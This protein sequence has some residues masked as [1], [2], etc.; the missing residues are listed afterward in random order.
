MKDPLDVLTVGTEELPP[1]G[2]DVVFQLGET[3]LPDAASSED[4]EP[5][6]DTVGNRADDLLEVLAVGIEVLPPEGREVVFQL[7]DKLL[8][9]VASEEDE[10]GNGTVGNDTNDPLDVLTVGTDTL[11]PDGREVLFQLGP[12]LLPEVIPAEED[13]AEDEAL[14]VGNEVL[15]PGGRAVLFQLGPTLLPEVSTPEDV[16]KGTKVPLGALVTGAD[17]F[18]PEGRDVLFQLGPKLLPEL[19]WLDSDKVGNGTNVPLEILTVGTE[20]FPLDVV[21]FQL[22]EPPELA[23]TEAVGN[24]TNVPLEILTVGTEPLPPETEVV[25]FHP[26]PTFPL[27]ERPGL[28]DSEAVGNGMVIVGNEPFPLSEV[29]FPPGAALP[30]DELPVFVRSEAVGNGM[31]VPLERL[32]VEIEPFPVGAEVVF[33][34]GP[35]LPPVIS[36]PVVTDTVEPVSVEIGPVLE[37]PPL[38]AVT[39]EFHPVRRVPLSTGLD[40]ELPGID[41]GSESLVAPDLVIPDEWVD[42]RDVTSERLWVPLLDGEVDAWSSLEKD[43]EKGPWSSAGDSVVVFHEAAESDLVKLSLA[44]LVV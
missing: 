17:V 33:H 31:K 30:L 35:T 11:P 32:T 43:A 37:I 2:R 27:E 22:D 24:G 39:L 26:G 28:A 7:G 6:S 4:D 19:P 3:L 13:C 23:E 14:S 12:K 21:P 44:D 42:A 8:P 41:H 9:A 40:V 38:G 25:P 36:E 15:P 1:G 20:L 29:V 16:G 10:P 5:G 18:P 34:A